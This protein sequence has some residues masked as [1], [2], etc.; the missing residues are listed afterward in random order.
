[1][2]IEEAITMFLDYIAS[3]RRLSA[4]T[5]RTYHDALMEFCKYLGNNRIDTL[6]DIDSKI[7]REW[8]ITMMEE[9]MSARTVMKKI[10]ALKSW[11]KYLRK[12]GIVKGDI[13][14]KVS[15]LKFEK[16][17]PVFYKENEVSRLYNV[18]TFPDTFEGERDK[19]LLRM[20]YETGMRRAEIAGLTESSIDLSAMTIKV[21]GKRNKQRIIPIENEL[22]QNIKRYLA[23]KNKEYPNNENFYITKKGTALS[24]SNIYN[25]V[26]KYMSALSNADRI[27]PHVFRHTFATEM[28][29]EG[30]NIDAVKE[31]LGHSSLAATEIYTHV[32]REHLKET[33]K[34]A[35][36]RATAKNAKEQ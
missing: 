26:K 18:E 13:F 32:T 6:S 17:L 19:L 8:Q 24:T 14:T 28:L 36:P 34:H 9:G 2:K 27:S 15:T 12:Q 7:V 1:M 21:L 5:V 29:N 22:A 30:A 10:S 25:I 16:K 33:Y 35:H 3:E 23:L 31:L 11:H 4:L 20:L